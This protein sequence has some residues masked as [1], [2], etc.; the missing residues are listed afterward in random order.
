MPAQS[1][2]YFPTPP[3]GVVQCAKNGGLTALKPRRTMFFVHPKIPRHRGFLDVFVPLG[4]VQEVS[5][6][7]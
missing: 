4:E 6:V 7:G 2:L 1:V 5:N 3:L